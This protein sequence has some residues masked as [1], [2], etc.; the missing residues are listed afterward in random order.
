[1]KTK[2]YRQS[3]YLMYKDFFD[4]GLLE[5]HNNLRCR[6]I[7]TPSP[8]S[9]SN[10]C[11]YV[12]C[13]YFPGY[14]KPIKK[15]GKSGS[16]YVRYKNITENCTYPV[17]LDYMF[18]TP[19]TNIEH[20]L[21]S[22]FAKHR[23]HN[24]YCNSGS[25]EWF[26]GVSDADIISAFIMEDRKYSENRSGEAKVSLLNYSSLFDLYPYPYFSANLNYCEMLKG[27][28]MK[29]EDRSQINLLLDTVELLDWDSQ[30]LEKEQAVGSL[31]ALDHEERQ[32]WI[33]QKAVEATQLFTG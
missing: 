29:E 23:L 30:T 26:M 10:D 21:H 2:T 20:K 33:Y 8:Y 1:M 24:R 31:P 4:T 14:S 3:E 28:D 19:Y 18:Y 16:P 5:R 32:N 22:I 17:F 7:E 25:S 9:W 15:I 11:V 27:I 6:V 12:L 13:G